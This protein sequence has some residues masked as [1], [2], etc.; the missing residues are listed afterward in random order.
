M[1]IHARTLASKNRQLDLTKD[2]IFGLSWCFIRAL[3]IP[4]WQAS[5][6]YFEHEGLEGAI[7][8]WRNNSG[9]MFDY[10]FLILINS[11][12]NDAFLRHE[13]SSTALSLTPV[14]IDSLPKETRKETAKKLK[15]MYGEWKEK[16]DQESFVRLINPSIAIDEIVQLIEY[17]WITSYNAIVL[18][19]IDGEIPILPSGLIKKGDFAN[20]LEGTN[21][22]IINNDN[23]NELIL[24][25]RKTNN[26][27]KEVRLEEW[28]LSCLSSDGF[29]MPKEDLVEKMV[30]EGIASNKTEAI[31]KARQVPDSIRRKPG[32]RPRN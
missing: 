19:V 8:R 3:E 28:Y 12:L 9:K 26:T 20:W 30:A 15:D 11:V 14:V 31:F 25:M 21:L 1:E 22:N 27:G 10:F 6:W 7:D 4:L 5:S 29:L 24:K 16:I 32:K 23:K 2:S 13:H 18:A 17:N